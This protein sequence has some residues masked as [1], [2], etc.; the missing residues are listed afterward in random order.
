[1]HVANIRTKNILIGLKRVINNLII[2]FINVFYKM[3]YTL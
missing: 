3:A 1:M 2:I